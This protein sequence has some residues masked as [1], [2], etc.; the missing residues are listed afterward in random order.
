[1]STEARGLERPSSVAPF[2]LAGITWRCMIAAGGQAYVWRS[3]DGRLAVTRCGREFFAEAGGRRSVNGNP[4][5]VGAMAA[6]TRAAPPGQHYRS[7]RA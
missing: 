4:S 1:M 7:T 6:A 5:L 3:E 2:T